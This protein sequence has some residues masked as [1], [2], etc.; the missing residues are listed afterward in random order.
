MAT[1]SELRKEIE[2]IDETMISLLAK[3]FTLVKQI[4][5]LKLAEGLAIDDTK[6]EQYLLQLY[7]QWSR[8]YGVSTELVQQVFKPII[9]HAKQL[10]LS[11]KD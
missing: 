2:T 7:Q 1:I 6:R 9:M 11:Y 5:Q 4:G 3:R 10:Q 8:H